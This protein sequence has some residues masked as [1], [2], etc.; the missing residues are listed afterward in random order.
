MGHE[1]GLHYDTTMMSNNSKKIIQ[2]LKHESDLL[3]EIIGKKIT[4]VAQHNTSITKNIQKNIKKEK[5]LDSMNP[6]I[7]NK[8]EYLSDSVQNWRKGCMCNHIGKYNKM[9]I[10][11][12]PFWWNDISIKRKKIW[13]IFY[14][15]ERKKLNLLIKKNN[16]LHKYYFE[17]VLKNEKF[18]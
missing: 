14:D 9:Q 7:L 3:S 13:Q 15:V 4:S 10:L 8:V 12:H 5:F 6:T 18:V 1:I 17:V 11:T 2:Q 16:L